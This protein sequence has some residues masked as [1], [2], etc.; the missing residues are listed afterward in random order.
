MIPVFESP[1]KLGRC[2][3]EG[4]VSDELDHLGTVVEELV[5]QVYYPGVVVVGT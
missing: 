2:L 5:G 1:Y 3:R 4:V